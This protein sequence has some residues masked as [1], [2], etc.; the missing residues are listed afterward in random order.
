MTL[1]DC[2]LFVQVP[3]ELF[4]DLSWE[5]TSSLEETT[6]TTI[7]LCPQQPNHTINGTRNSDHPTRR[8]RIVIADLDEKSEEIRGEYWKSLE[9]E[10]IS[11]GYYL[12][13]GKLDT[14]VKDCDLDDVVWTSD[15]VKW[16]GHVF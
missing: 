16:N 6:P 8:I 3:R 7:P 12:G 4:P 11:G 5:E 9:A 1:R 10:L 2:T 13:N 15:E 14:S